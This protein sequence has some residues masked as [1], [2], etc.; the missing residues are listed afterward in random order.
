[1][2]RGHASSEEVSLSEPCHPSIYDG[3]HRKEQPA[4]KVL[5][6]PIVRLWKAFRSWGTLARQQALEEALSRT[7]DENA[8]RD[9]EW[10]YWFPPN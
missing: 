6:H 4:V 1:M 7:S 8:K 3:M 9:A 10:N 5:A 2:S